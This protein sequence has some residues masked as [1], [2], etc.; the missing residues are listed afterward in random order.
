IAME[1]NIFLAGRSFSGARIF[2]RLDWPSNYGRTR[3]VRDLLIDA[4]HLHEYDPDH[5]F[6]P[7]DFYDYAAA[8]ATPDLMV[9]VASN[10]G[11]H[12]VR[13]SSET[14]RRC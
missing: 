12:D 6:N 5:V 3:S 7:R 8:E 14:G 10:A 1:S 2:D 13:L 4:A 9:D 11:W